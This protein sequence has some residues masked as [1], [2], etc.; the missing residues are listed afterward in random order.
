MFFLFQGYILRL[1]VD[2]PGCTV[3]FSV[4]QPEVSNGT[5]PGFGSSSECLCYKAG[6]L[7]LGKTTGR[8]DPKGG[9]VYIDFVLYIT[10]TVCIYYIY[11]LYIYTL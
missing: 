2:L 6:Q 1:H 3:F 10:Y 7:G 9:G 11:T 8:A 5:T 4:L